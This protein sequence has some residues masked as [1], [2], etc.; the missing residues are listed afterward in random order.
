MKYTLKNFEQQISAATASAGELLSSSGAVRALHEVERHF[1]VAQVVEESVQYEVE[2]IITPGKIK[3]YTCECWSE[4]RRLMC[5][6]IVAALYKIRQFLAQRAD[7]KRE[8]NEAAKAIAAIPTRITIT[9]ILERADPEALLEFVRSYARQD[10]DFAQMLKTWFAGS[11]TEATNPYTLV[12]EAVLPKKSGLL[13]L[14]EP[15]FRRLHH[16]TAQLHQQADAALEAAQYPKVLQIASAIV[17][18]LAPLLST[19]ESNKR[20]QVLSRDFTPMLKYLCM[21]AALPELSVEMRSSVWGTLEYLA[22]KD[23]FPLYVQSEIWP[24]LLE[25][26]DQEVRFTALRQVFDRTPFPAPGFLLEWFLGALARR[27][28]PRA[29][30]RVLEDYHGQPNLLYGA[31]IRLHDAGMEDA[32]MLSATQAVS[33]QYLLEWQRRDLEQKQYRMASNKQDTKWLNAYFQKKLMEKGQLEWYEKLKALHGGTIPDLENLLA[34]LHKNGY[35]AATA[36]VLA[37]DSRTEALADLLLNDDQWVLLQRY[38]GH[39]LPDRRDFIRTLYLEKLTGYLREHLGRPASGFVRERL[40]V[41]LQKGEKAL[42]LD[43]MRALAAQFPDRHTL[44]EELGELFPKS[45]L[46]DL[47]P[48]S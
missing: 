8:K 5:P 43:I 12:L 45:K 46:K 33:G 21:L 29:A 3:A 34:Q 23:Q 17:L 25:L 6:H 11:L 41:L 9:H 2:V 47:F 7:E 27:N 38:E 44:P 16:T 35:K 32:F 15:D 18:A 22:E 37:A 48:T 19:T 39:F 4:Q 24:E 26:S 13:T 30:A 1:W 42:V 36:A 14:K 31:L 20:Q 28:T 40:G 10:A